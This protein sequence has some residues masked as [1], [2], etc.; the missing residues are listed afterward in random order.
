[1]V[2]W[3][4][5]LHQ[6]FR[7]MMQCLLMCMSDFSSIHHVC[8]LEHLPYLGYALFSLK[9]MVD[10]SSSRRIYSS[11]QT[12]TYWALFWLS[13]T[14]E[15]V[16]LQQGHLAATVSTAVNTP[17]TSMS[18]IA[19]GSASAGPVKVVHR[20]E[21]SIFNFNICHQYEF[22]IWIDMSMLCL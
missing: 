4:L 7:F 16:Y 8:F 13:E 22:L 21:L 14:S 9:M 1:M 15:V 6:T 11:W 12:C 3:S 19:G 20:Y 17:I 10:S 2:T 5:C 18:T